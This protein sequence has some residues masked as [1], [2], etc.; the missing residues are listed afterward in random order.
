M[1]FSIVQFVGV[2][3]LYIGSTLSMFFENEKPALKQQIQAEFDKNADQ[4]APVP[5]RG[6][7]SGSRGSLTEEE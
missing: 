3:Y 7:Q 2:M 6:D 5:T 1:G 4:K